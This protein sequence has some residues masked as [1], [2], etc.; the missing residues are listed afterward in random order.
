MPAHKLIYVFKNGR[1]RHINNFGLGQTGRYRTNVW[2]YNGFNSTQGVERK[3]MEGHPTPKPV[4]MVADAMI[5]CSNPGDIIQDLFIG[6]GTSIIAAEQVDRK[7]YGQELSP[8]YCDLT[9]RRYIRFMRQ[10]RKPFTIT[11][12]GLKLT[13]IQ[14]KEYEQ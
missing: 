12:N 10:M 11:K 3:E 6:S 8:A 2:D 9:I 13:N 1:E 14:L 4:K 7:C 5:D